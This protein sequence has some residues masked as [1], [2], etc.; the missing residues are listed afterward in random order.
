MWCWDLNWITVCLTCFAISLIP[1]IIFFEG[2]KNTTL[3]WAHKGSHSDKAV[4]TTMHHSSLAAERIEFQAED[5]HT[6]V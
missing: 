1:T 5:S 3:E 2:E 6:D 4:L